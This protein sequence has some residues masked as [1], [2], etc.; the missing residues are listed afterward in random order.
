MTDET[1]RL[2]ERAHAEAPNDEL[3]LHRLQD[4]RVRRGLGWHGERTPRG[5]ANG[6]ALW[7]LKSERGVYEWWFD[8]VSEVV[9]IQFVYV[10]GGEV[11]CE[12]CRGTRRYFERPCAF[13]D[14]TGKRSIAPFYLGRFPVTW[15]EWAAYVAA[16]PDRGLS[17]W[18]EAR[19]SGASLTGLASEVLKTYTTHERGRHPVVNVSLDD[20]RAFWAWAELRL[21]I[22]AEWKWAALG[23]PQ[24]CGHSA[25]GKAH[26]TDG[27]TRH[28]GS[29]YGCSPCPGRALRRFPWGN[30][31]PSPERCTYSR[32]GDDSWRSGG[33]WGT[34]PVVVE[35]RHAPNC[36]SISEA[37]A[38]LEAFKQGIS[39][40][41]P[42]G[43]CTCS[44]PRLVPARP[45]GASWCGA[46]DMAG[47]VWEFV[48]GLG[49]PAACGGSFRGDER[50]L[51][52]T[53]APQ[54]L[55]LFSRRYGETPTEIGI[56]DDVGFR[57]ALSASVPS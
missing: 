22:E 46:H 17:M 48:E 43:T 41:G 23:A 7:P 37:K 14:A 6:G 8:G 35:G 57:V 16:H 55:N 44:A 2:L 29:D 50:S 34:A 5:A 12:D 13:C 25:A 36:Q 21:P 30:E 1:L 39:Y 38:A 52:A 15:L 53:W 28:D 19:T 47:N 40:V 54:N 49:V 26:C 24:S 51:C 42:K 31:P 45:L 27:A 9:R 11:E 3:V 20:A 4:E 56:R 33:H 32:G 10:P 18:R